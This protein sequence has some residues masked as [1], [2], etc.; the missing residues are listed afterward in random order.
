[1]R[2]MYVGMRYLEAVLEDIEGHASQ[3]VRDASTAASNERAECVGPFLTLS[4][5]VHLEQLIC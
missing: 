5:E 2:V 4:C 3:P 1:M